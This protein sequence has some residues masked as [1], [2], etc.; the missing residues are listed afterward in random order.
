[1]PPAIGD[2]KHTTP[3]TPVF[4]PEMTHF[5]P[6]VKYVTTVVKR[7]TDEMTQGISAVPT[8]TA[9]V[10]AAANAMKEGL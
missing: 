6:V 9:L 1:M 8:A 4:T 10:N 5:T 3:E 2:V 7:S